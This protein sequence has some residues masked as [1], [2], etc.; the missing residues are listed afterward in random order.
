MIKLALKKKRLAD[1]RQLNI[2]VSVWSVIGVVEAPNSS[3]STLGQYLDAR[4]KGHLNN[5]WWHSKNY[6]MLH[7]GRIL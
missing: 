6:S 5:Y 7:T 3:S 4:K 2:T 1:E